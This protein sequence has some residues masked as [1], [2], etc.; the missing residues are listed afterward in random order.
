MHVRK[1]SG[2][3]DSGL[4]EVYA[5]GSA[6]MTIK[7]HVLD[8]IGDPWMEFTPVAGGVLGEDISLCRKI[9]NAGF[10]IHVDLDNHIGHLTTVAAWPAYHEGEWKGSI[11]FQQGAP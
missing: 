1:T 11:D 2:Y 7:K 10:K 6:G 5:A 4:I 3:P 8:A 9:R